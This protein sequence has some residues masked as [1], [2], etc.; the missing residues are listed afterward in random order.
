[1]SIIIST[2]VA[3]ILLLVGVGCFYLNWRKPYLQPTTAPKTNRAQLKLQ[4]QARQTITAAQPGLKWLYLTSQIALWLGIACWLVS[5]YLLEAKLDLLVFPTALSWVSA[6]LMVAGGALLLVYPLVWPSQSYTYWV[7]HA[8]NKQAFVPADTKSFNRYRRQQIWGTV[9]IAAAGILLWASRILAIGTQ[10]V[11]SVQD[12]IMA[13]IAAIP[14][15][16]LVVLLAQIPYLHQNRYLL[17][18][19]NEIRWGQRHYQATKALLH[20]DPTLK[21]KVITAHVIR[22]VGYVL[23]LVSIFILYR[24][25]IAPAFSVD[26]TAVFPATIIALV[27]LICV[28]AV[29]F[30]WPA[31]HYEDFDRLD[32]TNL[33]FKIAEP[34]TVARF[35]Y[36]L[37]VSHV[38]ASII[39]IAIWLIILA[40]YYYVTL[41]AAYS[42]YSY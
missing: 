1:M 32:T 18:E 12:L 6:S 21:T 33:P 9:A 27:G 24:N 30:F 36:H 17:V 25:I 40:S 16:A 42:S 37:R 26:L 11:I 29:S 41:M 23:G 8:S 28:E 20:H 14:I 7:N 39:W 4:Q 15:I 19:S 5:L 3:V 10:P 34:T 2:I 31:H 13:L 22:I 38:A 35:R